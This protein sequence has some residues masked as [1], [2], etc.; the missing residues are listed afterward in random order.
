MLAKSPNLVSNLLWHKLQLV[1]QPLPS[2]R[3]GDSQQL[4]GQPLAT[5]PGM[6]LE[7]E[8]VISHF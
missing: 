5:S 7:A 3:A 8:K 2:L 4:G 1:N 6:V